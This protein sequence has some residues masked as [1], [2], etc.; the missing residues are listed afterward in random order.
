MKKF[1]CYVAGKSGGHIIP[2]LTHAKSFLQAHTDHELLFFSTTSPLDYSL[3]HS[4]SMV[5][6]HK[7]LELG[8]VPRKKI[9]A[10]PIFL[11]QLCK[12]GIQTF[13]HLYKYKP[14]KVVSMG[15]YVSVPVCIIARIM[16]IPVELF[17]LNVVPGQAAKLLSRIA[18]RTHLCFA[19]TQYQLPKRAS[20]L[21]SDYPVRYTQAD[22]LSKE[23]ACKLLGIDPKKKVICVLGGSQGSQFLN[24]CVTSSAK[25]VSPDEY[26]FIHQTGVHTAEAV[27]QEYRMHGVHAQVFAFRDDI[28]LCY[29]AADIIVARAGAG[30]LFEILFFNKR[31]LIIPLEASTTD[32]Q[33]DNA[34]AMADAHPELFELFIQKTLECDPDKLASFF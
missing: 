12:T 29:S 32:H 13:M 25:Q 6:Q 24:D 14:V 28:H 2:A 18:T 3:L 7:P 19:Q 17:E 34:R 20:C 15:G 31:A 9:M 26:Y 11:W 21:L 33:V 8:N 5:N 30:T 10:W 16:G 4:N 23:Q 1:I 27:E 22:R